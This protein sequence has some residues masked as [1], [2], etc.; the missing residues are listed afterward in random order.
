MPLSIEIEGLRLSTGVT[1]KLYFATAGYTTTPSD[2]PPN[3]F[4]EPRIKTAPTLGRVIF[5][6]AAVYGASRATAGNVDLVNQDGALDRL[7]TDYAFE[8]RPFVVKSGEWSAGYAGWTVVMSGTLGSVG[9]S[10]NIVSFVIRDRLVDLDTWTRPTYAGTN[11]LPAGLEGTADDLKGQTKPRGYG[12]FMNGTPKLVNTSKQIYQASDQAGTVT[13]AY[14]LGVLLTR[15]ADY[16]SLA[17]LEATAPAAGD[18]RCFQGYFRIGS[19]PSAIT[20]DFETAEVRPAYLLRQIALDAGIPASDI[21]A[22]LL[23]NTSPVGVFADADATPRQLM[24]MIASSVGAWYMFDRLNKLRMG[25]IVAPS[26]PPVETWTVSQAITAEIK[27]YI[28]PCWKVTLRYGKNYTVQTRLETS[29]SISPRA[30]FLAEEFRTATHE[31]A[32]I[33]TAWPN[34]IELTFDS[35]LLNEADATAECTRLF[36]L[37][38]VPRTLVSMTM[39]PAEIGAADLNSVALADQP[40]YGLASRP[41]LVTGIDPGAGPNLAEIVLWG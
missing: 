29:V 37:Y 36:A 40:R 32:T 35:Y 38:G 31:D 41:L 22:D 30:G 3:I 24:D 20:C 25:V 15:G 17:D 23:P 4:F 16:T 7:I 6:S 27:S 33:K 12:R 21:S 9:T 19:S 39:P 18:F 11:V 34:A 13:A 26:G 2:T 10:K 28:A 8:G 5:D 1:E 14:D